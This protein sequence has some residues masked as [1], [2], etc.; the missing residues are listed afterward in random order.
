MGYCLVGNMENPGDQ[1]KSAGKNRKLKP[2]T[3]PSVADKCI[4]TE[5]GPE[6]AP[7]FPVEEC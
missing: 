7:L 1:A 5:E 2:I 3:S 6:T 4:G